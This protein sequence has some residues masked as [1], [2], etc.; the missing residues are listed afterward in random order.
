M[1]NGGRDEGEAGP[2][3]ADV[4]DA[5]ARPRNW[6]V[7]MA[8]LMLR[9]RR[10]HGH[11]LMERATEFGFGELNPGTLY[12]TLSRMEKEG[13][14]HSEWEGSEDGRSARRRAY[15]ITEAGVTHL[16]LWASSLRRWQPLMD[17]FCL[18]YG[19]EAPS[20]RDG[21]K[22][23]GESE[24]GDDRGQSTGTSNPPPED[25]EAK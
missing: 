21:E 4:R 13:L 3:P 19:G 7:A 12:R 10:S 2:H 1:S 8:L 9:E 23:W 17:V 22:D 20:D 25:P 18:I 15:S 14:C 16:N 24:N 5:E 11:G 6:P